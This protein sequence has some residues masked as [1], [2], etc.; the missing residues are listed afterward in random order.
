VILLLPVVKFCISQILIIGAIIAVRQM[1]FVRNADLGFSKES[2][3]VLQGNADGLY[4]SRQSAF[5]NELLRSS[6]VKDVSRPYVEAAFF[7]E[8]IHA[9]EDQIIDV[10]KITV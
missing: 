7:K 5:K 9:E 3:L 6:R 10:L 4:L 8:I 1:Q 2:V